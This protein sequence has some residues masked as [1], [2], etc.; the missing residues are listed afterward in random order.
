M[1]YQFGVLSSLQCNGD[2]IGQRATIGIIGGS[3]KISLN[4]ITP[5]GMEV[6]PNGVLDMNR[7]LHLTI[8]IY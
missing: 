4:M 3:E 8:G 7:S 1:Y 5:C 6:P 2:S